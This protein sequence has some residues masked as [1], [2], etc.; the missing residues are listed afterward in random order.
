[1][2]QLEIVAAGEIVHVIGQAN[3]AL[4]ILKRLRAVRA[5]LY[6]TPSLKRGF[7]ADA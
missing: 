2:V 7:D 6:G 5:G 1:L 4:G 3:E